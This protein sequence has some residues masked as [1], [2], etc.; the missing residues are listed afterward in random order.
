MTEGITNT[1][2]EAIIDDLLTKMFNPK[3]NVTAI[4]KATVKN[5]ALKLSKLFIEIINAFNQ[6]VYEDTYVDRVISEMDI[7][8]MNYEN[9]L[10]LITNKNVASSVGTIWYTFF[11]TAMGELENKISDKMLFTY[12]ESKINKILLERLRK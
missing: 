11:I 9:L 2:I 3:A 4:T 5:E 10:N 6:N 1:E 7:F 12:G 8:S